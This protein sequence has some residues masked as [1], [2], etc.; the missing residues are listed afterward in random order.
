LFLAL[1]PLIPDLA[2]AALLSVT[3]DALLLLT[4]AARLLA[5]VPLTFTSIP[6][7]VFAAFVIASRWNGQNRPDAAHGERARDKSDAAQPARPKDA[8]VHA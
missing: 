1:I 3:L 6:D 2:L 8:L 4:L 7:L 5:C